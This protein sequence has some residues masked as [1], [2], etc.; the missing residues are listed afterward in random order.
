M[1]G[2]LIGAERKDPIFP[3]NREVFAWMSGGAFSFMAFACN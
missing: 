1:I 2:D 3:W